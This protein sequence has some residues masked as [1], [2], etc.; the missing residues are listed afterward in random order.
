MKQSPQN[1]NDTGLSMIF[2]LA[3]LI[4]TG[5]IGGAMVKIVT[6]DQL[7]NAFYSTSATARS[8]AQSGIVAAIQRLE[9]RNDIVQYLQ[10]FIDASKT[11]TNV[12]DTDLWLTGSS[13]SSWYDDLSGTALQYR[14][15]MIAF[16][17]E[18]F[19]VTLMSEGI[20]RGRARAIST[21]V[22]HLEGLEYDTKVGVKP[23]NALHLG[24]GG[25]RIHTQ[26]DVHGDTYVRGKGILEPLNLGPSHFRGKFRVGPT[27]TAADTFGLFSA[28]FHDVAYFESPVFLRS[29][30]DIT[31]SMPMDSAYSYAYASI[32]AE[33]VITLTIHQKKGT[34]EYYPLDLIVKTGSLYLNKKIRYG[35][36]GAGD[37]LNPYVAPYYKGTVVEN[38]SVSIWNGVTLHANSKFVDGSNVA[39]AVARPTSKINIPAA[40]GIDAS[41]PALTVNPT[42][43]AALRAVAKEVTP[44]S[45][46]GDR[47]NTEYNSTSNA[48]HKYNGWLVLKYK[49]GG[50]KAFQSGGTPFAG[51]VVWLVEGSQE[52]IGDSHMYEHGSTTGCTFMFVTGTAKFNGIGGMGRFR[53]FI[54]SESSATQLFRTKTGSAYY[55]GLYIQDGKGAFN[56]EGP[57][58]T[59][60]PDPNA[61]LTI[62]EDAAAMSEIQQLKIFYDPT[63]TAT[64]TET[65][66]LKDSFSNITADLIS[67]SM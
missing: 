38:G 19:N 26:I 51:K 37:L 62:Y 17:K 13:A 40:L 36:D 58:S 6:G 3:A 60:T 56:L 7:S 39:K 29:H 22:Y 43:L 65:I 24:S 33:D 21:A 20:G 50:G 16:D 63:A 28:R 49:Q 9:S 1:R 4:V 2:V 11:G 31:N 46:D 42:V 61:S 8:A 12:V 35:V 34:F 14:T 25:D 52:I 30:S 47:M 53:G 32:G 59:S 41:N 64:T 10:R 54:F 55:G 44:S 67:Q 15:K 45:W 66:K 23:S 18:R 57:P 27:L 48:P 5:F